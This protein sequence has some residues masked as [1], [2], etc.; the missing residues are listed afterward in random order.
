APR[1]DRLLVAATAAFV[2]VGPPLLLLF[3]DEPPSCGDSCASSVIVVHRSPTIEHAIDIA[4]SVVAAVLIALI[5]AVLV[6]RCRAASVA[7]RR[8]L[9]PVYLAGVGTLVL[10]LVSNALSSFSSGAAD[11]LGPVFLLLF[12]TVPIAFLLGILRSRLARGSVAGL[13]VALGQGRQLRAAI[14][15]AIGDPTLELAYCVDDGNRLVDR[16]GRRFDLPEGG[17]GRA[18]TMVQLE[19]RR[20]GA[21]VHDR[22]LREEE[23]EL[24]DSVAATVALALDNERLQ[25]ELQAQ[26]DFLT[27]IVDPA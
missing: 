13:A 18:A 23:P 14:A 7:L 11:A 24:V 4:G 12:A 10:L 25:A 15:E 26:Y 2:L 8:I 3:A 20:I 6:R 9:L 17:S 27:T 21:L 1:P 19:G 16:E 5:V 22:S